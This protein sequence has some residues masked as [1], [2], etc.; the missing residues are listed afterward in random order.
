MPES[1][2][3]SS[4]APPSADSHAPPVVPDQSPSPRRSSGK[5]RVVFIIL[6]V[7]LAVVFCFWG[8]PAISHMLHTVSTDDAYVNGHA[9]FVAPRVGGQVA[10]VLVDD[11]NRVHVGDVLVE[12]DKEP[13]QVQVNIRQ[14]ALDAAQADLRAAEASVAA[15]AAQARSYR[16]KLDHAIEEV[17]GQVS[18]LRAR[19]ATLQQAKASLTLAQS[20]FDRTKGLLR[21][22]AVSQQDF[23]QRREALD[24]AQAQLNQALENI[25][26]TRVSLGLPPQPPAGKDLADVPA[27]LSQTFSSVREAQ[28]SLLQVAS[29]IGIVPSSFNLTPQEML[30]EFYRRDPQKNVDRI[31]SEVMKDAPAR[32]QAEAKVQEAQ[33]DLDQAKLNLSYCEVKAEIDGVITRRNVNPGNNVQVGESLMVIRSLK[34][35]WIDANF[36]ETQLRDLRIGQ[37]V[38]LDVDMYGG[39]HTFKGRISGFTMGTGSTLALLPAQNATGNFI[40][41]VQRLPVRIELVDYNPDSPTPLFIGLSVEPSVWISEPPTGPDAGKFL[42]PYPTLAPPPPT[43]P[44]APA[45]PKSSS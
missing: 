30:N 1:P 29:Q 35:I 31:L 45:Q 33:R 11:N 9:T 16:F 43:Q 12:L 7:V 2:Q 40:K 17:N 25:Y 18:L 24:V 27:D 8:L 39:R 21:T 36:K 10:K 5:K 3:E 44:V 38:D 6:V 22:N 34:D 41:V 4:A 37:R 26:Q 32:K 23:D 20:D 14:A 42:Q 15:T 13:Y 28:L 19:V